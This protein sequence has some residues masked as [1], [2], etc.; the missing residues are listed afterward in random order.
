MLDPACCSG[1]MTKMARPRFLAFMGAALVTIVA[2][3]HDHNET[4]VVNPPP[5]DAKAD[6]RSD[7]A[8]DA[9]G[10]ADRAASV[11]GGSGDA[12]IDATDASDTG[13]GV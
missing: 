12:G 6:V 2:G 4:L 7:G 5:T 10:G 3:C 1:G 11:D 9:T 13:G 8:G